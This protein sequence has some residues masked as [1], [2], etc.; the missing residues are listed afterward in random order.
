MENKKKA[1]VMQ[2]YFFP[3]LGYFQLINAVDTFVLYDDV[4]FIMRG[5]INRNN[6]LVNGQAHLISIPL[7]KASQNR[8]IS[9]T[10]LDPDTK[11]KAR[12]LKTV[13]AAYRKAPEFEK[14]FPLFVDLLDTSC[15]GIA[16]LNFKTV[17]MVCEY[18]TINTTI[19]QSSAIYENSNLKGQFRVLDICLQNKAQVYINPIGG[20]AIYDRQVFTEKN[21]EI[22]FLK[23]QFSPYAQ[24]NFEFVPGLSILDYLMFLPVEEIKNRLEE[25][26]LETN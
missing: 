14:V 7:V 22:Y 18:L 3:Y 26:S 10:A 16:E 11:W 12:L 21:V 24:F 8:I 19:V 9:E 5:W 20:M 4:N 17:K 1:A 15:A 23:T 6:I 13:E 2:P 25:Y